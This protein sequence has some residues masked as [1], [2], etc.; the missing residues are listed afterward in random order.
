MNEP[1]LGT[2]TESVTVNNALTLVGLLA[3]V[4]LKS[5][6]FVIGVAPTGT[7]TT[8]ITSFVASFANVPVE[9]IEIEP[10][11]II[12]ELTTAGGFV[13]VSP[14]ANVIVFVAI[15]AIVN[16]W[17]AITTLSPTT[18]VPI[19]FNVAVV[20]VVAVICWVLTIS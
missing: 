5:K 18:N 9:T 19:A 7:V 17:P 11:F 2:I 6:F 16:V 8:A 4:I 14:K 13:K 10:I 15:E 1:K 3:D 12:G 20:E